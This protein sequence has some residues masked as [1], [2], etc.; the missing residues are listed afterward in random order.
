MDKATPKAD[1]YKANL[2]RAA[3]AAVHACFAN[4]G[5]LCI[6]I[7]RIYVERP[8]AE[9]FIPAFVEH[10]ASMRVGSSLCRAGRRLNPRRRGSFS[11]RATGSPR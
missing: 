4:S 7:E 5:Q 9:R 11:P 1:I 6:S 3:E 8:A 10:A 2:D